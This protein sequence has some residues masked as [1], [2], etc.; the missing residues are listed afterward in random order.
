MEN[1]IQLF[2]DP[3]FL[4]YI[5]A[6]INIILVVVIWISANYIKKSM[7]NIISVTQLQ[8]SASEQMEKT[9]NAMLDSM[10]RMAELRNEINNKKPKEKTKKI[11]S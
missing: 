4:Q 9:F 7:K 1:L 3:V 2:R 10:L 11:S 5:L 8:I 6:I